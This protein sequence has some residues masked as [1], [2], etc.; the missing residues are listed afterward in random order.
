MQDETTN[1]TRLVGRYLLAAAI[2]PLGVVVGVGG[3]VHNWSRKLRGRARRT[4]PEPV[5]RPDGS[6]LRKVG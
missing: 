3:V 4:A 5:G 6:G 1:K 2:I